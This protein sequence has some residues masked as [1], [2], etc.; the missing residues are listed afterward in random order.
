LSFEKLGSAI[1]NIKDLNNLSSDQRNMKNDLF[2]GLVMEI[3]KNKDGLSIDE[4]IDKMQ[5]SKLNPAVINDAMTLAVNQPE[6]SFENKGNELSEALRKHDISA[7]FES[8]NNSADS[9]T[10]TMK[11][12]NNNANLE[13]AEKSTTSFAS[14]FKTH[15]G[16]G[17]EKVHTKFSNGITK[18]KAKLG[19]LKTSLSHIGTGLKE[20]MVANL[21]AVLL[22]AGTAAAA[23]VNAL[24]NN[25]RSRALNAGT[26]NL[27]KYNKK[28]NKSQS[29]LDSV[30]DIKAEFNRLAKGVD[31][32]TN[33]NVGL[34]ESDY[35]RYLELKKQLVKT[36]KDLV[37]SMDSEGNAIID[38]NSAIDK[39][40]KKYERQIQ[41]NKQAI[42][43]KKNL[44]IQN[45]A[46][47]LNMNKT[48]EGNR[49]GDR[50]LTGNVGRLLTGG[51]KGVGIGG[52]LI[53]G[54]IG[55]LIA[56]GAG[57]AIGAVIGNG[58]QAAANLGGQLL[59]GT[60]D[61]GAIHS[62]FASK[63]SIQSDGLNSNKS[64][65][66]SMIK[67]TKAYKKEAKSILGKNADLDNLTDQQLST[68][69]NNANF[70]GGGFFGVKDNTISKYA[71]A[72]K[73]GLKQVQ[74]Y[75]K[76]FKSTT[77]ENT[78]EAS[79]GFAT[80]DKTSR[81]FAKNYVSNMDLSSDKMSGEGATKYLEEQEQ[82]VRSFTSKL[83]TD[84]SLK[85]AY[86]KFSDIKGDTSK[87]AT[88]WQQEINKQFK[89]LKDKTGLSNKELSGALGIS[90][91]GDDVLTS[92]GRNVN[93]MIDKLTSE[94]S[95]KG[96][97]YFK[98]LGLDQLSDAYDLITDKNEIF[99]GSL[100]QLK[101]RLDTLTKYKNSGESFSLETYQKAVDSADDDAHYNTFVSGLKSAKE[102]Y[103]A[104]KVGT[105]QFKQ[106]AGLISPTGKT[107]DKNFKENYDHIM[108]YFTSDDSGPKAFVSQ[109]QNMTNA[110]G[111]AMATLD[112]KTGDYKVNIDNTA[113]AAKKMGMGLVPFES[114]LDNLKTYGWKVDYSSLTE[115]WDD[116]STKLNEWSQIW[117]K[118][119]GSLG[120]SQGKEIEDYKQ[121]LEEFRKEGEKL[122]DNWEKTL[123]IKVNAAE[124]TT[125]LT[126][127]VDDYKQ[128]LKDNGDSWAK[129]SEAKKARQEIFDDGSSATTKAE[130]AQK[131][132]L[133]EDGLK[134]NQKY[135]TERDKADK[136]VQN[137]LTKAKES[138]SAKDMDAYQ[139]TV[140]DRNDLI[141]KG[142]TDEKYY[143]KTQFKNR[144]EVNKELKRNGA[145]VDKDGNVTAGKDNKKDIQTIIDS[146][147]KNHKG[148]EIKV[149]WADGKAPKKDEKSESS[150]KKTKDDSST[151]SEK[152]KKQEKPESSEKGNKSPSLLGKFNN[153]IKGSQTKETKGDYKKPAE[154]SGKKTG[155]TDKKYESVKS[156]F[157][158]IPSNLNGLFKNAQTKQAST[159][160]QRPKVQGTQSW[161]TDNTKYNKAVSSAKK[162]GGDVV[163]GAK[164]LGSSALSGAKS[165]LGSIGSG[166]KGLFGGSKSSASAS[167]N[168]SKKQSSKSDVKVNVKGN[169]KK[170][171]DSIKKSLSSMKSKSISIKVKGNAKKTISSISKSLKKL[172]SKSVSIKAKG[173]AS[174]V[175][176]KI[177]SALKKLKNKNITVKVK[178]SASSKISS[179]K[180]KLNALGKMHP[181]PKVTINTSGLHDVEAAKSA[182]NGLHDKSVNVSVNYSQSGSKPSKAY[183]TFAR[184]SMAWSTAYAKGTA[185]ALAGGNIGAKTSGKTLVGELGVEAIIPKNSQRMFLLG[186]T[187]PEFADIHSGDIVFNH[188]Q[189]ADLLANGHTS[190][191][192]KV[193]GGM[194]A[195]A[196][197]TSF[198]AL[199][200][201]QSATASGG[202]RGGIAEKSGSSS[203][204]KHTE[205]TKKNTEATK[206]NTDSKKKD[207]KA[208]DKSTKKKSKFA[209]LLDNMGKQFD[210][211]AIAIDR[212]AT[213]TENFANM[214]NDYVKP[215]TKQSAL[216]NQYKSTG[217]EI[218]VNQQAASKYK[219]EAS[220]FASKAIKTVPKTKNSSK[221]KNQKRLRTYFER[222]RNGSMNINTIK[223]DNMRSAVESYQNLWENYIK[224]N[225]AAQQLKNTQRDLF[226]QWLNMPTEKAQ[227]AIENLQNSYDTLSNR[228][229]AASTGESGIARL[230]QTSND[231]LYEAQSNVSSAQST[232]SR[233]SSANKTAQKKVSKATKSQKSKAKSATKAVSKSG[234]SK[235]KKASLNKSIKAGKTISTKGLKGSAKKKATAYNK[236]VKSTKSAKSS[237]AKTSANLSNANSALYDA[238]VYL[239]NLQDSQAIASNYAGQPAYAYQN[240]VLKS[241]VDNKK[242]QY[243]NSQTAVRE[244]SKNQAKY[245]KERENAQANKNKADSAVKTKGNSILSG[246]K[247][248]KLSNSQKNAIKSGKEVSLKGIKDKTLLKQLKAYNEQ[249]KKAKDAS[250]KLAQAKQKEA[251]A[252]N[253]LAT[254]NKNAND[255]AADWA[256]EQTNAA[257]QSQA[258]I[259]A[260]YDAKANM[261]A[262]NSSNA[263]SAAKLKQSK[264]QD[265]DASDYQNQMDANERQAQIIDEEAAKMQENLNNKLNDG[266]IKYGS[267]EWMQMQNEINACKGSADDLRAS[268]EELKNSMRDDIYYRGFERAI[269]AAQN[270][271]NSLTT[272]SSLIDE[273]AMFDDDGN[274]T[275]YGTAAIATNIANVRSEKEELNQLMQE[276]AKMAEHRDEY[277]DTEWADAIQKSDQDIADAVKSIKSAEDSVT[278]ILKNNAK[279]KLD[280]TT[281]VIQS[282]QEAI[283]KSNE[284]Y[285]YD[286]QLKSSN[287]DIQILKSQINALNGVADAA[288]KSK[289]ARLEA[290]LQ[291]KQDALDD[292][293]KDHIYNLQIDGLDKLSTQLNDDYE[294]YCKELSSSV[295]KIEETFTSLSGTIS[296][297][298]AKIDST[299]TTILG[300]YGVKPSD[301]GLT[302]S[303]VAGYAQGGLVK[304]VHKNGDDGLAS[305]AVGE[306]VATVDVVNLANKV[307]QDKVL[308]ALANGHMLNGM[309]MDG[310][311]T[312][313]INVNFGEAIGAINVPSGVSD[314]ELQRIVNESYKYTSQK[315]TR[316][317][318]KIVGRKRPV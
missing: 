260:Y 153:W 8:I 11:R 57:T 47:A 298:G 26:K 22:A 156:W 253:A 19:K 130:K 10:E 182:I 311:G 270:L 137:A 20:T 300:H 131:A 236:A 276:R 241:Q 294:K 45:K 59:L 218:S 90:L 87:N 233:A 305:L 261:E 81:E 171:I 1:K 31:N 18:T 38:N 250:N 309:T 247:A 229:S 58:V 117:E 235:K 197:G 110:S 219:S 189:T 125:K 200:S 221:K 68:L 167:Q 30:N 56:P 77:L 23:G 232:Q 63:K 127:A 287:K 4:Q 132:T 257:V 108:K 95:S 33:Q 100:D 204:K 135:K 316:D 154:G 165:I 295:D 51:K 208:T 14:K 52:A 173:N 180:G 124:A 194:S 271:Q 191:R 275:D 29:K 178:D 249:V 98:N 282:Y 245:Q 280:A 301:L 198:K 286:K 134:T 230:V 64:N 285:T 240:D 304:S 84:S 146:Y 199:S 289:K 141:G 67:N 72:T 70:D 15:V 86:E 183:G 281:K 227:K 168:A 259:K 186:T 293:V 82:K 222:V 166:I 239:K 283:K 99:T 79:Q 109:L 115:Q 145:T 268:N 101:K 314:E 17:V 112:K 155:D 42:A 142:A 73:D 277:S 264:G 255:A 39:S 196:H 126:N 164:N 35:S 69:L 88:E 43:S 41:K 21:P 12:F 291:E 223:N 203:T 94:F 85:D 37:K 231:Q 302:D 75:L 123:T 116:A 118:N 207:S 61:S 296:S 308:N 9:A 139:K 262:T 290:E 246:K 102:E 303:K 24:A 228:S 284:Y 244:A 49:V 92:D 214:I 175:I 36:N 216:W 317:M 254:A 111:E 292:T 256:A 213:A 16:G 174:S 279:Q 202:W 306:E 151:K 226:N 103:D 149:T 252:T 89:A 162:F 177:A 138:G 220:S 288:S 265:L 258:N 147:N 278:T 299:I 225:S 27:N 215:E 65:L 211:I 50:S 192:A 187:G 48:T 129:S 159:S 25:I 152:P 176:K 297:E 172:K 7:S 188:Q 184:G 193:Q 307:R 161:Q 190:T 93:K 121:K 143:V 105:D 46:A 40:I 157:K 318:A 133:K 148:S 78:L 181:T 114:M 272:I 195:F 2:S 201:G 312:T 54:A 32:T 310:I 150:T 266:S 74:D 3:A 273:D 237:A 55:T 71:D 163:S 44:A 238:Q 119:G 267:Q 66:I 274:L 91:S 263:S 217:K 170:T 28:I 242:K 5:K 96:K 13:K 106:M 212:A 60:K 6:S 315:V 169:A 83:A 209:T 113:K 144:N 210:F 107:D 313:E 224:C 179:I 128:K 206:K 234:L 76:E 62:I 243:E 205:S 34:S 104:G 136:K 97:N 185:N 53:G 251:D 160:Y 269:K 158:S 122:P 80:L 120:D 248:K 140:Q